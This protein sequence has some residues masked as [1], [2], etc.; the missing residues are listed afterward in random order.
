MLQNA[1]EA[2]DRMDKSQDR[3]IRLQMKI[4]KNF[5]FIKCENSRNPEEGTSDEI[6]IR[7]G[8]G[9]GL[10]AMRKIAEKHDSVLAVKQQPGTF[11]VSSA[12]YLAQ[13]SVQPDLDS[14][15]LISEFETKSQKPLQSSS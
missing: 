4:H 5:L 13:L 2:C 1:L 9:Y 14:R 3:F 15:S 6:R 11:E 10:A 12:F 8:H 7:P